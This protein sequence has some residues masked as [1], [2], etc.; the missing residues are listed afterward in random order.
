METCNDILK[1]VHKIWGESDVYSDVFSMLGIRT[2]ANIRGKMCRPFNLHF[3]VI[4][5]VS[6]E[7]GLFCSEALFPSHYAQSSEF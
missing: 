5:T 3:E 6:K 1:I 4:W 2:K 7:S